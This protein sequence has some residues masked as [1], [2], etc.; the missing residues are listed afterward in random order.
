MRISDW[1]SDVCSSD[2]EVVIA[3]FFN[4]DP[5]LVR[6]AMD[7]LWDTVSP[8]ALIDARFEAAAAM[9]RRALGELASGPDLEEAAALARTAAEH[10]ALHLSGDRKSTRMNSSH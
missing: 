4:F 3:T 2:L 10:G 6:H 1:S 9:L 8:A 5:G 7:G